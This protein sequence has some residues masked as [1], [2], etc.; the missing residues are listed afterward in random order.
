ML[1]SKY[2]FYLHADGNWL[3]Y[4][5]ASGNC[6]VLPESKFATFKNIECSGEEIDQYYSLGF[7]IN[8]GEDEV[9]RLLTRSDQCRM[10]YNKKKYRVLTTTGCNAACPYCYEAGVK[11]TTMD[12]GTAKAV[13]EF[14]KNQS[15]DAKEIEIEWFGGEPLLNTQAIDWISKDILQTDNLAKSKYKSS[16]IT[17]GY[18]ISEK[19]ATQMVDDWKIYK[20]QITLDG[21]KNE[22]ERVKGLGPGSFERVIHNIDIIVSKGIKTN[23][24]LNFDK[25]NVSELKK[26]IEYLSR[27]PFKDRIRVYAAP[28]NHGHVENLS[29][30]ERGTKEIYRLLHDYGF[31]NK[32]Q[33]LPRT[34][35][36][37]C[38]ASYPGYYMINA[39]GLIFKCDRK[40]LPENSVGNVFT[41]TI[42]DNRCKQEWEN[43]PLP[44][45]CTNCKLLPV[46]WGGCTY[47]RKNNQGQCHITD[48]IV[49]S[50]LELLMSDY[51]SYIS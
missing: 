36:T 41:Q 22:Y 51:L 46:C 43:L 32:L 7:Y 45:K 33:L 24:R 10:Y 16:I 50:R 30:L 5:V 34:M 4:N 14:I 8:N 15:R 49:H 42:D 29:D 2:N 20:A 6:V 26:L 39:D 37:P 19:L 25:S 44:E 9:Q 28:I 12:R 21:Y 38:S 47:E 31:M 40:L 35:K 27:L 18:L 13:A 23:I 3:I 1:L 11:T 17:N 48:A